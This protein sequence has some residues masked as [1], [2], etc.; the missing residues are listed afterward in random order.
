MSGLSCSTQ[1]LFFRCAGSVVVAGELSCPAAH[2]ILVLW[3]EM[4]PASPALEGGFI[5]TEPP[6]SSLVSLW[7]HCSFPYITLPFFVWSS[8]SAKMLVSVTSHFS[9]YNREPQNNPGLKK[10]FSSLVKV[11]LRNLGLLWW[12]CDGQR[13]GFCSDTLPASA[14]GVQD[15]TSS[16]CH[17]SYFPVKMW[18][19]VKGSL[20]WS[21][22][23][24]YFRSHPV[25]LDLVMFLHPELQRRKGNVLFGSV[26]PIIIFLCKKGRMDVGV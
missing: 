16:L 20:L 17:H 4:E 12:P 10:A 23:T 18:K 24:R 1:A 2:G 6:G 11:W 5:I 21:Q 8:S 26:Y 14:H 15:G 25:H 7:V 3:P 13:P 9:C 19:R 22:N